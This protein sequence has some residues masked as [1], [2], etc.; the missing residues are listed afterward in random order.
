MREQAHIYVD[1]GGQSRPKQ[2]HYTDESYLQGERLDGGFEVKDKPDTPT[3]EV[4]SA[5]PFVYAESDFQPH[6]VKNQPSETT[7]TVHLGQTVVYLP[8]EEPSYVDPDRGRKAKA[9]AV[10][11]AVQLAIE[12]GE[13]DPDALS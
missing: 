2:P 7:T 4:I 13:I 3:H 9:K 6:Y 1:L 8:P 11:K 10:A 5:N 12:R